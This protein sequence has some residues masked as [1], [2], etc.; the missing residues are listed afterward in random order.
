MSKHACTYV[1]THVG[2]EPRNIA[3]HFFLVQVLVLYIS[4]HS[5]YI[6][7]LLYTSLS[8]HCVAVYVHLFKYL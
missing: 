8:T 1:A 5:L 4:G 7:S 3:I 6:P 2:E